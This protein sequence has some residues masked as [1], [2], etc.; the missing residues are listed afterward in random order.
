[1]VSNVSITLL[2]GS[3]MFLVTTLLGAQ[4]LADSTRKRINHLFAEWNR[5]NTPGFSVGIVRNDSLIFSQ[6]YGM[7]N[8]EYGLPITDNT[9]FYIASVSKQ[10]TGYCLVLLER[11]KKVNLDED[12][13]VY[14]P[15]FPDFNQKIT[16]RNLLN[17]TSGIRD[18]L[19][20]IAISGLGIDGVLT[21][22]QVVRTLKRQ[23]A[24][25]FTPETRYSYSNSNY[26]LLGEIIKE[27]SG[28][29]IRQFAD[30]AVFKPL[31]MVNTHF[32]D[33]PAELVQNRAISYWPAGKSMYANAVQNIYTVGDGG[34]MTTVRDAAKWVMNFYHPQAVDKQDIATLTKRSRLTNGKE[35]SYASGITVSEEAGWKVYTHA[36]ALHGYSAIISVYPE[37]KTGFIMLSNLRTGDMGSRV[38]ELARLLIRP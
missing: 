38:N 35:L 32:H 31:R 6:G 13:R 25:N 22:E 28:Q 19:N 11:Q 9:I 7:A 36:G 2:L 27:V 18:H 37:V 23:R 16:V 8:L 29:S 17:H 4:P 34:M 20:M 30:S 15:W 26:V 14:L 12:I 33:N 5:K 24:L 3:W 10:F 1:M 21:N